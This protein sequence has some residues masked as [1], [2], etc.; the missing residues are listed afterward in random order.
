M[1]LRKNKT[2]TWICPCCGIPTK[3]DVKHCTKRRLRREAK[4]EI[5]EELKEI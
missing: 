1:K 4:K 2:G 5:R 3:K